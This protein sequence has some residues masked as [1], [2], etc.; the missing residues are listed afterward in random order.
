MA[1]DWIGGAGRRAEMALHVCLPE[2]SQEVNT[3]GVNTST[4]GVVL[5]D[6]TTDTFLTSAYINNP[7]VISTNFTKFL[8]GSGH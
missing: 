6:G 5:N 4:G 7:T 8:T 2:L 3:L 1:P